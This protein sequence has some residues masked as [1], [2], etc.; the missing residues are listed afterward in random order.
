MIHTIICWDCS[1]RNFFHTI[2]ALLT[3]DY[4]RDKFELIYVEQRSREF[5]DAYNHRLGLKSLWDRYQEVK[6]LIN[7]RVV[8]LNDPPNIPYHLGRIVNKALKLAK[9][10]IISVMDGDL[11]VPPDFLIKLEEYHRRHD[12]AIV[13]LVRHMCERPV[14]VDKDNWTK[15][16]IDFERC[17]EVCPT[18]DQPIPRTVANKGPLISARKE[19]WEKIGGYDEHIIW[20]TGVSRLG[21][22]VTAR[23]EIL[24]GVESIALPDC[25]AVHP[26]HPQGFRRD[27]I[28]S[29]RM[30]TL[31]AKL[32]EWARSHSEPLWKKRLPYTEELYK[33][34]KEFI[35]RFIYSGLQ[36]PGTP[37]D[38]ESIWMRIRG[39][40]GRIYRKIIAFRERYLSK[41]V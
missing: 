27:T 15:Q 38:V 41:P 21:Q 34:H 39:F 31:Q 26:W 11:L 23:L 22:D 17:L 29:Q 20:S 12:P 2:D 8:Y 10:E 3:Q 33:Q 1:F 30:L 14:G 24:T 36:Q 6:D 7:I 25:F 40:I 16:I 35:N 5:S 4:D 9:G 18:R 19:F 28:S 32:I 13:N 37:V